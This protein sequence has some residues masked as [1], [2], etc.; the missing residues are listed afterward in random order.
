MSERYGFLG[1]VAMLVGCSQAASETP[2]ENQS[3]N[4]ARAVVTASLRDPDSARFG[5]FS[6]GRGASIC[7]SVNARNGYGGYTGKRG[8][9]FTPGEGALLYDPA[10]WG[11]HVEMFEERGCKVGADHARLLANRAAM[12]RILSEK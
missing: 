12:M 4:A 8:F 3:F 10:Q 5:P 11:V 1:A 6:R 7:G 2:R 9:V